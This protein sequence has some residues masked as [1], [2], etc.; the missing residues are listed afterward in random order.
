[1][2]NPRPSQC[3]IDEFIDAFGSIYEHSPWVAEQLYPKLTPEM[4]QALVLASAME[5]IVDA[6]PAAQQLALLRAHPELVGKLDLAELTRESQSEQTGAGLT[7]CTPAEFAE[8]R[9]LNER[10]NSQFGFP[11]IFAVGGFHRTDI[12]ASFRERVNNDPATEFSTALTQVHRI[13]RLRLTA[14]ESAE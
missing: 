7:E 6:A 4:D 8:F 13:G 14:M 12:L 10:Y 2:L 11:F 9:D 1:M 5:A 3:N